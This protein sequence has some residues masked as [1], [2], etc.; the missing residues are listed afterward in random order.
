M[1]N[2]KVT[3]VAA[4]AVVVGCGFTASAD[5]PASAYVQNGLV[6]QFDGI[7]N[8]GTGTHDPSATVWKDLVAANEGAYDMTLTANGSFTG[9]ALVS[10]GKKTAA[11][12]TSPAVTIAQI[13]GCFTLDSDKTANSAVYATGLVTGSNMDWCIG[14]LSSHRGYIFGGNTPMFAVGNDYSGFHT[15]SSTKS[16]CFYDG[17]SDAVTK[18]ANNNFGRSTARQ[19]GT[20]A[21]GGFGD[22]DTPCAAKMHAIRLYSRALMP[23]EAL[24]NAA[25]DRLRFSAVPPASLRWN[26]QA[27]KIEAHFSILVPG[28]TVALPGAE[29]GE[30]VEGWFELGKEVSFTVSCPEGMS[31]QKWIGGKVTAGEEPGSFTTLVRDVQLQAFIGNESRTWTGGGDGTDWFDA[32]NWEPVGAP[33]EGAVVTLPAGETVTL[34]NSTPKLSAIE[35][36]GTLATTNWET[37][38]RAKSVVV[39][40]GGKVTV[41]GLSTDQA[42]NRVWIVCD[43]CTIVAGGSIDVDDLGFRGSKATLAQYGGKVSDVSGP[44]KGTGLN[45]GASHGGHGGY[46]ASKGLDKTKF[47]NVLP[48]DN[49]LKPLLP[50]SGGYPQ[51]WGAGTDGG[52]A[53]YISAKGNVRVDG[54]IK[55]SVTKTVGNRGTSGSG[56]AVLIECATFSGTGG[57]I[58]A[59]GGGSS[60]TI[61]TIVGDGNGGAAG[62]GGMIAIKYDPAK[63][64]E[65]MIA[66][67]TIS[68]SSGLYDTKQTFGD[69]TVRFE[70]G[71]GTVYFPDN[72]LLKDLLGRGLSGALVNC[73]SYE[74]EG[75]LVFSRGYLRFA[76]EGAML[77]V[78]GNLAVDGKMSR[79]DIGGV[80]ITNQCTVAGIWAG[81]QTN[82]LEVAGALEIRNGGRLDLRAAETNANVSIG[83]YL[84]VGGRLSIFTNSTLSCWSDQANMGSP[85][86]EADS[87][88]LEEGGLATGFMRGCG[89]GKGL[90]GGK[91]ASGGSHGGKSGGGTYSA[92]AQNPYDDE[93]LPTMPGS[94]GSNGSWAAGG[95]GGGVVYISVA[96]EATVNGTINVD[97][98]PAIGSHSG[99][100]GAGGTIQIRCRT[101]FGGE[102]G[103]LTAKGCDGMSTKSVGGGSGGGG[104]RIAIWC[105]AP[106]GPDVSRFRIKPFTDVEAYPEF[107]S[108]AMTTNVTGG[109]GAG[110]GAAVPTDPKTIADPGT[111]R[112]VYVRDKPGM[113]VL[114]R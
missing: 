105:G 7:D 66:N 78:N 31:V 27:K 46:S 4:C 50:G 68:A 70:A 49:P 79:L 3:L 41:A 64:T 62:G 81:R 93:Y 113:R 26:E 104:G 40:N 53:V 1:K 11:K 24:H 97:G 69:E 25:L 55:A 88:L 103:V 95:L 15:I 91:N 77:K 20:A 109:V 33:C 6:V 100:G 38:V 106:W 114:V 18:G 98:M 37:C 5:I 108:F 54:A 28:G 61:A 44:G 72:K 12:G 84:K 39:A 23:A 75:D 19:P 14:L 101:F 57:S 22:S 107:F 94:G 58:S 47:Q 59:D 76:S 51:V 45:C 30:K 112:F 83:A 8:A 74:H 63:Q 16:D 52:G 99:G 17:L 65:D 73:K 102:T 29:A 36:A 96:R 42:T 32:A 56:G 89:P 48:Y 86:I 67:M 35:L 111:V 90:G 92:A 13:E 43:D 10:D 80:T 85:Y 9:T 71:L 82:I 110:S 2:L 21:V 34:S 60:A 87:F